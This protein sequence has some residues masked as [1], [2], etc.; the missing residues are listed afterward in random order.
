M[1]P[2]ISDNNQS[3]TPALPQHLNRDIAGIFDV[4]FFISIILLQ[5]AFILGRVSMIISEA[6]IAVKFHQGCCSETSYWATVSAR[7]TRFTL[8]WG[9]LRLC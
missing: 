9:R 8:T 7:R 3:I 2:E 1:I 5:F 6:Q 4:N